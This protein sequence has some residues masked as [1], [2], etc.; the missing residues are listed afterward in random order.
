MIVAGEVVALKPAF[1]WLGG[2]AETVKLRVSVQDLI[3]TLGARVADGITTR[4]TDLD[5]V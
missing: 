1:L 2:G 3:T 5:K 4:R